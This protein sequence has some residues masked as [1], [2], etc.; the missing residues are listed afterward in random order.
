MGLA[1]AH[2]SGFLR[3]VAPTAPLGAEVLKTQVLSMTI[4]IVEIKLGGDI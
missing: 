3:L 1:K 4:G 2:A